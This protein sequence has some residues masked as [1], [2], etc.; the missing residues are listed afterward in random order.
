MYFVCIPDTIVAE[1]P[2]ITERDVEVAVISWF[3]HAGDRVKQ[4]K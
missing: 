4:E 3:C 2:G 1:R